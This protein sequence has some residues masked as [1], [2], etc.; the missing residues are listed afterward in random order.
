[1]TIFFRLLEAID[2]RPVLDQLS[3]S[4]RSN[5]SDGRIFQTNTESFKAFPGASFAYW[6]GESIRSAF[7]THSAF[8]SADT[9][10]VARRGVN[11]NDDFR[12]LRSWHEVVAESERW[13]AHPKG[14]EFRPF[15]SDVNLV[16]DWY[17]GGAY[18][19]AP[20]VTEKVYK[21]AIVPS[22]ELY[23][24][25]GLTWSRRTKSRL[26]MRVMPRGCIF[27]DKGPAVIE[28]NDNEENLFWG[29]AICLSSAY[30]KL[31]EV[32]LAAAD[33]RPGGAAHSFE[34]GVIQ[35]TPSPIPNDAEKERLA[36]L[37]R[38][39]WSLK[40]TLDT[41][42]E[43]SH[44]FSLPYPLRQRIGEFD[45]S[46]IELEVAGIQSEIDQ[47]AFDL[48]GFDE[49]DRAI[50]FDPSHSTQ[51]GVSEEPGLAE[52]SDE[53]EGADLIDEAD[54]LTSWAV[55][56]AVGRFDWRLATNER[57][58]PSEPDPFDALPTKSAGM[59]PDDAEPFHINS[60]I[61]VDDLGHSHDL[62]RL[63]E[64][65]FAR[66]DAPVPG[67]VR[68]W[69]RRDF[70]PLHLRL[71]SKSRRKAPIY[72]PLSTPSGSYTLWLYYPSLTSQTLY[73]A[74]NDFIDP[75]LKHVGRDV[76]SLREKGG[77]RSREDEKAFEILQA[78]ELELIELRDTLLRIA[79]IYRPNHDDGVQITAAPLWQLFGHKPWQKVLKDTWVKLE[80]GDYD[81]AH[82][83]MAYWPSRV[84]EKCRTDKSLAIAHG[85]EDLY[86][87]AP[88]P[89]TRA[90][91][92]GEGS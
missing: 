53:E 22:K 88:A 56:V 92:K 70:F 85:L 16:V 68:R 19:E 11:S 37:A 79:P 4:F 14:G 71:Y 47:I 78:L 42:V 41:V 77:A 62:A 13:V 75:K 5:C 31:V 29:L 64:E 18:L 6:V 51:I 1:M 36:E 84:R 44:A 20:R 59:L 32:Q 80:K 76:S 40:R 8:E 54:A 66:V 55:G 33:A 7:R 43:T 91:K 17:L 10:F 38:R 52:D 23:F 83:A 25:P 86:E 89:K 2:K 28:Q 65:V 67:D 15:Y 21:S 49:R 12:F 24:R 46:S 48:Y 27:G 60:G 58:A 34:V 45:P 3:L 35:T 74:V 26:S 57:A 87:D 50:A 90:G 82:L 73:T 39:A 61:L 81:W 30:H 72:W 63:I 9:G 69:L